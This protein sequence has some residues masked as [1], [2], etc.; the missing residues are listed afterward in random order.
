MNIGDRAA[1]LMKVRRVVVS[2]LIKEGVIEET[3][4]GEHTFVNH[5]WAESVITQY[6]MAFVLDDMTDSVLALRDE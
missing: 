3:P 6:V 2:A 4:T 1:K 5:T